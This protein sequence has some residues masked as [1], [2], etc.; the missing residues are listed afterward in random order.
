MKSTAT[1]SPDLRPS[2][3]VAADNTA[4]P[5]TDVGDGLA[6]RNVG[7]TKEDS[8]TTI[9]ETFLGC[10]FPSQGLLLLDETGQLLQSNT[11]AREFCHILQNSSTDSQLFLSNQWLP[12]QLRVLCTFLVDALQTFPKQASQLQLRDEIF[13]ENG[14]RLSLNAEWIALEAPCI[15]VRLEDMTQSAGRR[16]LGDACR[17]HLTPREAEVWTLFLQGLSYQNISDQLFI[18]MSTVKKHMKSIHSKRRNGLLEFS[19]T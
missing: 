6:Q 14:L 18:T 10:L 3:D 7:H 1:I 12:R 13:L 19:I 11:K 5:Q 2:A 17:Y 16:A 15:L 4:R 9:F 8:L